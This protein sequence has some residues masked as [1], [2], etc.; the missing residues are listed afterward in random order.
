MTVTLTYDRDEAARFG[1]QPADIDAIPNDAFGQREV[2]QYFTGN[3]AYYVVLEVLPDQ[4][5]RLSTLQ[6][7]YVRAGPASAR[8]SSCSRSATSSR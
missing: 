5:S 4:E 8:C 7:L 1:V 6:K 3:K 2:A